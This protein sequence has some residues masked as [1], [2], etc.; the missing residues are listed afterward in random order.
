[1]GKFTD[2]LQEGIKAAEDVRKAK[3]EIDSVF[4]ELNKEIQGKYGSQIQI[5]RKYMSKTVNVPMS[6]RGLLDSL[7]REMTTLFPETKEIKYWAIVA[8]FVQKENIKEKQLALWE[9]SETG[10]PCEI[11]IAEVANRCE[12]KEALEEALL[13][14]LK[15]PSIAEKLLQLLNS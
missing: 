6:S 5:I 10:Y 8:T 9:P 4:D 3:N 1:M 15:N 13:E 12:D 7:A 14:M 2:A 11:K